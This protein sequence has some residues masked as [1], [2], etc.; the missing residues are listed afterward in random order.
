MSPNDYLK[1]IIWIKFKKQNKQD[2]P[3][4][5]STIVKNT[6]ANAIIF[7]FSLFYIRTI[8]KVVLFHPPWVADKGGKYNLWYAH[9]KN[10]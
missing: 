4:K 8:V 7:I 9:V 10:T 3:S 1:W 2:L 5:H 6:Y